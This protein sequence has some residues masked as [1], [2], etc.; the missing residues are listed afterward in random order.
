M[1]F[2]QVN[3]L[4]SARKKIHEIFKGFY[5]IPKATIFKWSIL[6]DTSCGDLHYPCKCD[7]L[8]KKTN[9]GAEIGLLI[10]SHASEIAD[11]DNMH[12]MNLQPEQLGQRLSK[13]SQRQLISFQPSQREMPVKYLQTDGDPQPS[14]VH[15]YDDTSHILLAKALNNPPNYFKFDVI[16]LDSDQSKVVETAMCGHKPRFIA[17]RA[18]YNESSLNPPIGVPLDPHVNPTANDVKARGNSWYVKFVCVCVR[19]HL[20]AHYDTE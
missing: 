18:T 19:T 5:N 1:T 9:L 2:I 17:Q 20:H 3:V 16:Q 12:I 15:Q 11:M 8:R 7:P 14:Y 4:R 13:L 10:S 6:K